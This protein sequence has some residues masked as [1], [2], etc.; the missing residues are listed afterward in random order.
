MSGSVDQL[1]DGL[2]GW[3][4]QRTVPSKV[5]VAPVPVQDDQE[6]QLVMR[7]L[8]KAVFALEDS[9]VHDGLPSGIVVPI[10]QV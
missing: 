9:A 8:G 1:D 3:A 4:V 5:L 7:S 10:E 2:V 6:A